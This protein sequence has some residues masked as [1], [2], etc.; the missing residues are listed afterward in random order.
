MKDSN[1]AVTNDLNN[2]YVNAHLMKNNDWTFIVREKD[3]L[4]IKALE[5]KNERVLMYACR[6]SEV[7]KLKKFKTALEDVSNEIESD[8]EKD[9]K[10]KGKKKSKK[11]E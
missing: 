4:N 5:N 10:S 8:N 6:E 7:K 3:I 1:Q 11:N 9:S 2:N